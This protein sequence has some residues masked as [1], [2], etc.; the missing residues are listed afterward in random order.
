[1]SVK[2]EYLYV[3]F[4]DAT[5]SGSL[6]AGGSAQAFTHTTSLAA[7]ILRLGLNY[8]FAA[9]ARS[10]SLAPPVRL[11]AKMPVWHAPAVS[12]DWEVE[13]GARAWFSSGT[14]GAPQPLLS[15]NGA[16]VSRITFA[17]QDAVSG[18]TFVRIDHA[19]GVF[20]KGFIGAGA[21]N[22]GT[23]NDEDFPADVAYS[24]TL[25]SSSGSI[26]YGTLDLGYAF[27]RAPGARVWVFAGYNYYHQH[28]NTYG[29]TQLAGD[30]VCAPAGSVPANV[31]ALA[32][33]DRFN[34]LR[35]GVSAQVM[36]TDRLKLTA[37][38]AY[39]PWV[40]F[41]GQDDHNLPPAPDS[42][43]ICERQRGHA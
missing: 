43:S 18:E 23:M 2:A 33:D 31:M 37:E 14:I 20:V 34:S 10:E 1:L 38:A 11:P 26:G 41:K 40:N 27:L 6:P 30:E 7:N 32:E 9:D 42:G 4:S 24:N 36:L 29:C 35:L 25:Q 19:S 17:G 13:A 8:R 28:V 5:V 39:L 16:L 21:I 15:I 12:T 3:R 22:R